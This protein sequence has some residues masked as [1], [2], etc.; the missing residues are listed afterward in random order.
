M[1]QENPITREI[2]TSRLIVLN[3]NMNECGDINRMRLICIQSIIL[4][5]LERSLYFHFHKEI[6]KKL[7]KAQIGF[8]GVIGRE[9]NLL[10]LR[11]K[12]MDLKLQNNDNIFVLFIDITG[13]YDNINH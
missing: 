12:C 13:V 3:K 10:R 8:I 4:K 6:I 2:A 9:I 7:N 11:E 1:T 5:L